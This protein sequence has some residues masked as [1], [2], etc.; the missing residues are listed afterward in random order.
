[1]HIE[2]YF[3]V[4]VVHHTVD[5]ELAN[6]VESVMVPEIDKL[7]RNEL[8]TQFS[9]FFENKIPVHELLPQ[10]VDE[11]IKVMRRYQFMTS[12]HIAEH[13]PL[14]Y[15]TQDY[16][17]GDTHGIHAHGI[18]GIS[19]VYWVRAN[20]SA[21]KIRL[22]NPNP[23]TDYAKS[24]DDENIYAWTNTD[25]TPEKGKM[26]LFPSYLKHEVLKSGPG[27][28]RTTIAFNFAGE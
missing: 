13:Q 27:A 5:D 14:Q 15:W 4:G 20:E 7:N 9:D 16:K 18:H 26:I 22:H 1:M 24:N 3:P 10:L 11:W 28:V 19:G 23:M 17:E 25:I 6:K 2:N 21:G 8:D 12:L